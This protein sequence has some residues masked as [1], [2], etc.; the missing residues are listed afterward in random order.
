MSEK[1][2]SRLAPFIQEYLYRS[3][4]V[5]L[6]NIQV[7]ASQAIF[8][9]PGHVL[10]SS[11]T[12]S[13]KTEAAFLPILTNLYDNPPKSIGAIYISPLKALLNDQFHRLRDLLEQA[14]IPVQNW[15]GDVT[16]SQKQKFFQQAEGILQIT[17]ESLEAMLMLHQGDLNR[18]FGDLRFIVIDEV[19]AFMGND[20][21]QQII[22]QLQRLAR[23]Q[24]APPRRIGLSATLGDPQFAMQWLAGGTKLP[25]SLIADS[26]AHREVMIGLEHFY[27]LPARFESR[28]KR[29]QSHEDAE[30]IAALQKIKDLSQTFFQHLYAMT[31]QEKKTLIFTN[32]RA[33]TEEIANNLRALAAQDKKP[34]IYY[35]HHGSVSVALRTAAESAMKEPDHPACVVATVTL[36]MGIDLGQLD[37]VLQINAPPS[38]SSF[39]QRLGRSGRRGNPS[40]MFLYNRESPTDD[41]APAE[42]QIPWDLLETIAIIQLYLEEKW[43]EPPE[44]RQLPFSLLYHQTMSYVSANTEVTWSELIERVLTLAPFVSIT[45]A[46]YQTLIQHLLEINHLQRIET[47]ALII[48]LVGE[49]IVNDFHFY[50]TFNNELTYQVHDAA[51]EIGTVQAVPARG[52]HFALASRSW[53]VLAVDTNKQVISVEPAEGK[54]RSLWLG[55]G[56]E[57]HSRILQRIRQVLREN[58]DYSYLRDNAKKRVLAARQ[59]AQQHQFTDKQ[60]L[61]IDKGKYLVLPWQGTRVF[62]TMIML[63]EHEGFEVVENGLSFYFEFDAPL[64]DIKDIGL[65]LTKIIANPPAGSDLISK[66]P[67]KSLEKDKYDAFVPETLLR[68]TFIS[69]HL[70]IAAAVD[71]LIQIV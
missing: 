22:C 39:V 30:Q 51:G 33:A 1:P 26:A 8:D 16:Q 67:R 69:T 13:G 20:R 10:I 18:V 15:H 55:D 27:Q 64:I 5:E 68:E 37:Q 46:Q 9:T 63:L 61:S 12:A 49:K 43:L 47:G 34:D 35:I 41:Q 59:L 57:L 54:A 36:E 56:R 21:G 32:A 19:H 4:W 7:Q 70:D 11:S 29:A 23:L 50:A 14:S 2:F 45:Q 58:N 24:L 48:G 71:A 6:R 17:P 66:L 3:G 60:L 53:K 65:A 52:D 62:E 28:L 44:Q 25:V 31:Q 38:V 40:K 42:K